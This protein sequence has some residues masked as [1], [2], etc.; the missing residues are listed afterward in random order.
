MLKIYVEVLIVNLLLWF[1]TVG[2]MMVML[3]G[4]HFDK[5]K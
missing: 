5:Y 4:F 1:I 3:L 2:F